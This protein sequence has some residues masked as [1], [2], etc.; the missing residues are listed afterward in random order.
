VSATLSRLAAL[1]ATSFRQALRD[2]VLYVL[3]GFSSL[4]V[5]GSLV[6]SELTVGERGRIVMDLGLTATSLLANF[7]AVFVTVG[8]VAREIERRTIVVV[9]TKPVARWE[10]LVGRFVGMG[11]TLALM[12]A[13]MASLHAL[14]LLA[15][16][17]YRTTL[18]DAALMSFTES[19]LVCAIAL[20]LSSFA[21]PLPSVFL[22]LGFV[23]I[24]HTSW[25]LLMLADSLESRAARAGLRAL[26]AALP[27]LSLLN[28]RQTV[29]W[30]DPV[31]LDVVSLGMAY[32]LGYSMVLLILGAGLF[33]RRDL[34]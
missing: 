26:H 3:L 29:T 2:K 6:I 22:T 18:W 34:A 32:G 19:L 25:G 28:V 5:V 9:A 23:V 33:S 27:N 11:A 12:V 31:G 30:G 15:V 24:G 7:V 21:T 20:F 17:G 4:L 8:Q 14:V 16:D 10:I 1:G 13:V